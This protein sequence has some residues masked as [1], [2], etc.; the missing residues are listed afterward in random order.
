[1]LAR[2]RQ[3]NVDDS[4][5]SP[6]SLRSNTR[7]SWLYVDSREQ[8]QPAAAAPTP[9]SVARRAPRAATSMRLLYR[10]VSIFFVP[11]LPDSQL[12]ITNAQ[13]STVASLVGPRVTTVNYTVHTLHL[14]QFDTRLQRKRAPLSDEIGR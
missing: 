3:L 9:Q 4:N 5:A 11:E 2:T 13:K 14:P 10:G 6:L 8:R 7:S 1:M 12:T